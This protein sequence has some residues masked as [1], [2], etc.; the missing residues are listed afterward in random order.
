MENN[1]GRSGT[2]PTA[3]PPSLYHHPPTRVWNSPP[4]SL[5]W[6]LPPPARPSPLPAA[7]AF[8][9]AFSEM[10]S[11]LLLTNQIPYL[12]III[13]PPSLSDY[14]KHISALMLASKNVS[15]IFEISLRIY[16]SFFS[17]IYARFASIESS[18]RAYH[19]SIYLYKKTEWRSTENY[20]RSAVIIFSFCRNHAS[21]FRFCWPWSYTYRV[22]VMWCV[23]VYKQVIKGSFKHRHLFLTVYTT[24]N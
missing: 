8:R 10:L 23:C 5:F 12:F 3:I 7:R 19:N 15:K 24:V 13:H 1:S 6:G 9:R 22:Y 14:Q 20:L 4:R 11:E 2:Q 17:A 21:D 18:W 16:S